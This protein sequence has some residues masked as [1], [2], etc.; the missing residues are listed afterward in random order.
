MH[1]ERKINFSLPSAF[2][3]ALF[4]IGGEI[5]SVGR[6]SVSDAYSSG[7][8]FIIAILFIGAA[9]S[10][11]RSVFGED[12]PKPSKRITSAAF[13][14]LAAAAAIF[15]TIKSAMELSSFADEVML[16]R[17][18][19]YLVVP[20]FLM[21]CVLLSSRGAGVVKKY[22]FISAVAIVVGAVALIFLSLPSIDLRQ[23]ELSGGAPRSSSVAEAF[24]E[25]FAPLC[26][27]LVY[28]SCGRGR[29]SK[30]RKH[31]PISPLSASVGVLI[32]GAI[33][34]LVHF[35]VTLLLGSELA[36]E[37]SFPYSAAMSA[38]STGKLFMRMEGLS[39]L[40]YFLAATTRTS[41]ALGT[42][43]ALSMRF[44]KLKRKSSSEVERTE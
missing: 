18:P 33:L 15:V 38:V 34:T 39:Y 27:P 1:F 36:R 37:V 26:L 13:G 20:L 31:D 5:L 16:L 4:L 21:F 8:A 44:L 23:I 14:I 30:D 9:A 35:N 17:A 19:T 22:A 12:H 40:I 25:R 6:E 2:A 10:A 32:G 29:G 7:I 28:L 43:G 11:S 24:V 42:L 41:I 3:L